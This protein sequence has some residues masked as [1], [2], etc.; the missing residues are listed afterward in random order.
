MLTRWFRP[1]KGRCDLG[2]DVWPQETWRTRDE[3]SNR[4]KNEGF[5][6][7]S[8]LHRKIKY[9]MTQ[10]DQASESHVSLSPPL[11]QV[12]PSSACFRCDVCCRFPE[13]ES[14]LRPYF[15]AREIA[16]AVARGVMPDNFPDPAGSQIRLV[17]NPQGEGYLCP[18]FDPVTAHCGIYEA[19]PL[20]C[21]LYPLSLM[22][23]ASEDRVLLGWD[24]K[25]PF[26]RETVPAV[27]LAHAERVAALVT[28][29]SM[30][31]TIARHPRLVGPYQ[32]DVVVIKELPE[33]TARLTGC[34]VDSRLRRL[35]A[36]ELS[37]F[38]RAMADSGLLASG[39]LASYAF[40]YHFVWTSL[41][42]YWW[43][44]HHDKFYLFAQSPD[45]FFLAVPP[46]GPGPLGQCVREAFALMNRWNGPSPVS[47]IEN[48]TT[49]QKD[50]L[51]RAGFRC[52]PKPPDY[53]Y[54]AAALAD[55]KGDR[56]KS[57]RAL[58]NRASKDHAVLI[59]PYRASD[60][61]A[62]VH[63]HERWAVQKR[64]GR[65]DRMGQMLLEDAKAAHYLA[66]AEGGTL[67]LEGTVARVDGVICAYT[68]GYWLTPD[69]YCVLLEVADRS[70][71]GLAQLLF[72]DT[73]KRAAEGRAAFINAMDDAGLPGLREAKRAYRPVSLIEN[74]AVTEI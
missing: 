18:A 53:V 35:T 21:Q 39:P 61:A 15:T 69:T 16:A 55:L 25:C 60:R 46:L 59:E 1:Y 64:S 70:I 31:A 30:S 11:P 24:T 38:T 3:P 34:T 73:C 65:L 42:P 49:P 12:V 62:C 54:D 2:W 40:A 56:Y 14:F 68:F 13:A 19:R 66:L 26:M 6:L 9:V 29:E 43:M 36:S 5:L 63:L 47:R 7:R 71:T 28:T 74:W 4:E 23:N 67:G 48:V 50:E 52:L 45:G 20:D 8:E 51:V 32:D 27:I 33:L 22:W 58:C 37:R 10:A 17:K 41:L 57:Q 44:E 72:R